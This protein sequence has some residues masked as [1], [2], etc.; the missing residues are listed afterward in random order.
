[1]KG[2]ATRRASSGVHSLRAAH[3]GSALVAWN[4][5]SAVEGLGDGG[6]AVVDS[7]LV[8]DV[9]QVGLD[10]RF[11]DEQAR[12]GAAVAGALGDQLEDLELGG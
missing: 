2:R 7:E 12:G 3:V 8:V 9:H 1:M 10:G 5:Q 4:E 6:G 11:A